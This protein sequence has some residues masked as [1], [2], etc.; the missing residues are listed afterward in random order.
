MYSLLMQHWKKE[1]L[2]TMVT[3][4]I[5]TIITPKMQASSLP[6]QSVSRIKMCSCIRMSY[7]T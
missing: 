6:F 1:S 7:W 4:T 3:V 5:G 2:V